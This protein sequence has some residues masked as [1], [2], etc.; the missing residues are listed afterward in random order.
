[1]TTNPVSR[2]YDRLTPRERL[3]L[4]VAAAQ[5]GDAVENQSLVTS[6]PQEL[7][8]GPD[9]LPHAEA[10][11]DLATFH[12]LTLLDLGMHV[13]RWWG[14]WLTRNLRNQMASGS[15]EGQGGQTQDAKAQQTRAGCLMRYYA[16]RFVAHVDGWKQF[17]AELPIDPDALL[18]FMIGWDHIVW[19]ESQ[20]RE[21][22]FTPEDAARFVRLETVPVDP[23]ESRY[24]GPEPVATAAEIAADWHRIWT[25]LIGDNSEGTP[26]QSRPQDAP[27]FGATRQ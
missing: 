21:L 6:A 1:M 7:W 14:L 10:L 4:I 23:D 24:M 19:T 11:C 18:H 9:Y 27:W 3:P 26:T 15:P 25:R 12:R 5:R 20:A 17:C 13:W 8:E 16:A 2:W 22:A